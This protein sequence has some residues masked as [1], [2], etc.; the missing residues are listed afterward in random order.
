M[1]DSLKR[2]WVGFCQNL[3]HIFGRQLPRLGHTMHS[4]RL[5]CFT[6]CWDLN[7]NWIKW[8]WA[9][10]CIS[11]S[12]YIRRCWKRMKNPAEATCEKDMW[13]W[14]SRCCQQCWLWGDLWN[15]NR[16]QTTDVK[17]RFRKKTEEWTQKKITHIVGWRIVAIKG[18]PKYRLPTQ[19]EKTLNFRTIFL[20]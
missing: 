6:F 14:R 2:I 11:S 16:F 1:P 8:G 3:N 7:S 15:K 10:D 9:K 12:H 4:I 13:E 20:H 5:I 18:V 17:H 19:W